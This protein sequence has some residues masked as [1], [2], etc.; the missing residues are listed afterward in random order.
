MSIQTAAIELASSFGPCRRKPL[1][2]QFGRMRTRTASRFSYEIVGESL[3]EVML[4]QAIEFLPWVT[5]ALVQP[6]TAEIPGDCGTFQYTPDA[7]LYADGA[8]T[9]AECKCAREYFDNETVSRLQL[10]RRYFEAKHLRFVVLDEFDLGARVLQENLAKLWRVRK[11]HCLNDAAQAAAE[12]LRDGVQRTYSDA[13][14][15]GHS[16]FAIDRAIC[17]GLVHCELSRPIERAAV[18]PDA[19]GDWRDLLHKLKVLSQP[20]QHADLLAIPGVFQ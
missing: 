9:V 18:Q 7:L 3:L 12:Q 6:F 4:H 10:A 2:E 20:R 11:A 19:F 5:A 16:P 1:V 15:L 13:V 8:W 17:I 14:A